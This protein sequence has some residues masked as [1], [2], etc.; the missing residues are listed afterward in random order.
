MLNRFIKKRIAK[1]RRRQIEDLGYTLEH[2]IEATTK[3]ENHLLD[4][5]SRQYE[6][7]NYIAAL[8]LIDADLQILEVDRVSNLR[9]KYLALKNQPPV[10]PAPEPQTV[11]LSALASESSEWGSIAAPVTSTKSFDEIVEP[12]TPVSAV[13]KKGK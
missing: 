13:A 9:A 10:A 7:G 3:D 8:A 6:K 12:P 1:E 2:D 4:E 11:D 5:A